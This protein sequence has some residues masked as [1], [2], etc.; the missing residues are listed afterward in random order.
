[1]FIAEDAS[2]QLWERKKNRRFRRLRPPSAARTAF[3][4][5]ARQAASNAAAAAG[6]GT[7][8]DARNPADPHPAQFGQLP[9]PDPAD[10]NRRRNGG[11]GQQLPQPRQAQGRQ[12]LAVG[13]E[14]RAQ[15][16]R[17]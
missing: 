4:L 9:G 6:W 11:R 10:C 2:R 3:S 16:G 13:L 8:L 5:P 17:S 7:R 14:N 12:I 1:M 15:G